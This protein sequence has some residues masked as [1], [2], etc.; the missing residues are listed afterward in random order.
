MKR[1]FRVLILLLYSISMLAS[2]KNVSKNDTVSDTSSY[3]AES[4]EDTADQINSS[5]NESSSS[6]SALSGQNA[7]SGTT[8]TKSGQSSNNSQQPTGTAINYEKA[9]ITMNESSSVQIAGVSRQNTGEQVE[10]KINC[11]Q[12]STGYVYYMVDW[13]DGTWGYNGPFTYNVVS[14]AKHT[15]RKA[16]Q[17]EVHACAVNIDTGVRSSWSK[18]FKMS[19]SGSEIPYRYISNVQAI[20]SSSAGAGFLNANILDGKNDTVWRSETVNSASAAEYAGLVFDAQYTL[21]LVEIKFSTSCEAIPESIAIQYTTDG[22]KV[23]YDLPTYYYVMPYMTGK[24]TAKMNFIN[25]KG[26]TL[27]LNLNGI[28][29]NGIRIVSKNFDGSGT[30]YLEVSEMR[31]EGNKSTLFYSS[32]GGTYDADINN[33]WSIYGTAVTEPAVSNNIAGPN[34]DPFRSGCATITSQEWLEW[35]GKKLLWT[36][37]GK[38]VDVYKST[39]LSTYVGADDWG[40]STGFVWATSNSPKHLGVQNHYSNNPIFILAARNYLLMNRKDSSAFLDSVNN[41]NQKMYD[42]LDTA[43][44]YMLNVLDGKNGVMIIK[45]PKNDGTPT[46][47]S[48]NY[49]DAYRACGYKSAYENILFYASLNAMADIESVRGDSGKES[50]YRTLASK[51]YTEINNTFWD[52]AKGRYITSIDKNG[53]KHDYGMTFLNYMAVSYGLASNSY[54]QSIYDWVD[55]KR[56]IAGDTSTGSDIYGA[57]TY[58]SRSNT[59]DVSTT[60]KPYYWWDH[61]GQLPCTPNTFGGFGNQIQNGGNIFYTAHDDMTGRLLTIGTGSAYNRFKTIMTEFH[62][63]ELRRWK[64]TQ[65]GGYV[66]GI[67]GEFPESGLVPLT[68]LTGFIGVNPELEGLAIKPMLP[69]EFTFAGV[70]EY[71]YNGHVYAIEVNKSI[72]SPSIQQNGIGYTVKV[73]ASGKWMITTDNKI[74]RK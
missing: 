67:I 49:W 29:A 70:S 52:S 1:I 11:S 13:G 31:A 47:V 50:Y 15:Y 43:M 12:F 5:S 45:D 39:L 63:D 71:A 53:L 35:D 6:T 30:K 3:Y 28:V 54:A 74:V 10:I 9:V 16:G 55:G 60:G 56:T 68:F 65:Y 46:G 22:G 2:C 72:S 33:M 8:T 61:D 23:W 25:P 48:S 26:A 59:L 18:V 40:N 37:Y 51:A 58:N 20:S 62:K 66:E 42:R 36:T 73:P 38:G 69:D 17:Y 24:Y 44:K 41:K 34:P 21:D 27:A 57:F 14:S 19:V 4:T 64:F 32:K 7:N